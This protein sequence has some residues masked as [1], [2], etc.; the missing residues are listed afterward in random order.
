M[1][2]CSLQ[3]G[4]PGYLWPVSGASLR[5]QCEKGQLRQLRISLEASGTGEAPASSPPPG[6]LLSYL[7]FKPFSRNGGAS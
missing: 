3:G 1:T 7:C 4:V 6:D 2:R 5:L